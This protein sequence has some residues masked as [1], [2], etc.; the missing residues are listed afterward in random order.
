MV[1]DFLDKY[2]HEGFKYKEIIALLKNRHGIKI[3]PR[4]L[5][6]CLRRANFYRKGKQS[7]LLDIVT[8]IQ[9]EL[10]GSGSCIGYRAMHQRFIRNS[11]MVSRVIV[12]QVMKHLKPIGVNTRR[13]PALRHRLYYSQ[14]PNWVWHLD[15]YDRLKPYGFEIHGCIDGYSWRVLW[16]SVIQS[17]KD[18][19]EVCNL[20]LNYLL[21]AKGAPTIIVAD[22]GTENAGSQRFLR[23]NN[24]DNLSGCHSFQFGKS[25]ANHRIK[26]WSQLR[27]SCTDWW[28]RFFK[29]IVHEGIYDNTDS[30]QVECFKFCFFPLIQKELDDI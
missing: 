9:H 23:R 30:L 20:Y 26:F 24:S 10:E 25:I 4:T 16:L 3:S 22:R 14:G 13:R 17:T 19:K 2:F 21:I 15:G 12:A 29:E 27:R 28:I 1:K 11:L 18:P 8:F 6:H 7:P 5:H